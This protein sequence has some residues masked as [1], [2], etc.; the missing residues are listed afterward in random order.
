MTLIEV[1]VVVV[2]ISLVAG[3]VGVAVF[4]QLEKAQKK[5]AYTQIKHISE[6]LE[7]HKLSL[8]RFPS[9]AE[10]LQALTQPKGNE[11]PFMTNIPRD[12]WDNDYVYIYPGTQNTGSF[13]LLSY[14]PDGVQGGGDDINNWQSADQPTAE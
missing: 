11:K 13:D 8:R 3:V 1:M 6:A 14:G 4:G 12:P 5:L 10:G 7:L 2:I 9:T